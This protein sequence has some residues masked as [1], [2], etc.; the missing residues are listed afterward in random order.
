MYFKDK[1]KCILWYGWVVRE[2]Q[3]KD[4]YQGF[5]IWSSGRIALPLT[6]MGKSVRGTCFGVGEEQ[7]YKLLILLVD[8]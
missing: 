5:S 2:R 3:N 4:R 1:F 7:E 6:R 8:P